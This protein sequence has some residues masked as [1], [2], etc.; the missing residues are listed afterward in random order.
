MSK[1]ERKR[2]PRA[3]CV[4]FVTSPFGTSQWARNNERIVVL[5]TGRGTVNLS[6][7][8]S[9]NLARMLTA[10]A[11]SAKRLMGKFKRLESKLDEECSST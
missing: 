1:P 11:K 2:A 9:A 6:P 5:A 8:E 3:E 10:A 4:A 7:E